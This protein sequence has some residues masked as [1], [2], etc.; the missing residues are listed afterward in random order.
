[1]T[2]LSIQPPYPIITDTDG[3]PLEDGYIWIGVAGL[4]PIGNP[5]SVYWDAA[6]TQPAGL[7][8]RTQGGYPMNSGTPARLYVGSDYSILVLDK[9]GS[10]VY[11][12]LQATERYGALI[13]SSADISFLQAGTGAVVRT[14]QGKM[15]DIVNVLDF[16]ATANGVTDDTAAFQSANTAAA[17]KPVTVPPG[18]YKITGTLVG[19]YQSLGTQPTFVGGTVILN[20]IGKQT[21]RAAT[22]QDGISLQGRAGGTSNY[23]VALTPTTLSASR[24]A[25]FPDANITVAALQVA[26]TFSAQQTLTG[27]LVVQSIA[28]A[29]IAAIANAINT[30]NKVQGKV[31][32][33][34]TNNRLMVANG[35][36]AADPW[37]VA[38]GS[39]SV[40]PV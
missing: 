32:Y 18:S 7:P 36:L 5:I 9:N 26:Q 13:I 6:L 12:A 38:D 10:V 11:S 27:G 40:T 34:T 28:A 22:T 35:A 29:S 15:R 39:A 2:T 14:A 20:I 8:I 3:Q 4:N 37:Y 33:D 21:F 23:E 16:G 24:T 31:V 19:T 1:M 30:T 17:G 25:T